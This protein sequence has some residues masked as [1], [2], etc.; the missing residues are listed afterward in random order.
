MVAGLYVVL[1]NLSEKLPKTKDRI[2]L[3]NTLVL[4]NNKQ[5]TKIKV[6]KISFLAQSH[7]A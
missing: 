4:L 1:T 6:V 3:L 2:L 7:L 5:N